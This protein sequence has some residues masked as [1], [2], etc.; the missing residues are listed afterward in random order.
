MSTP[1]V[2]TVNKCICIVC[3]ILAW[4]LTDVHPAYSGAW[5]RSKKSYYLKFSLNDYIALSSFDRNGRRV[6]IASDGTVAGYFNEFSLFTYLEYGMTDRLTLVGSLPLKRV[7]NN[8]DSNRGLPANASAGI[9]DINIGLKYGLFTRPIVV[10]LM[11]GIK[12]PAY[13][14]SRNAAPSLGSAQVDGDFSLLIGRSLWPLPAYVTGDMGY[15]LR[16]GHFA[17]QLT[18]NFEV[19]V[20]L[21]SY[22]LLRGTLG[23]V[24][25]L[26]DIASMQ[27][28]TNNPNVGDQDYVNA[29][30][31][32]I[33]KVA[34][35]LDMS[36]DYTR[37]I[38]G[39]NAAVGN[40]I[41]VGVALK[42]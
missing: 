18:Y 22:V 38:S 3:L 12:L 7:S 21:G 33:F 19:G 13:A 28:M 9:G 42:R 17:N 5:A 6:E 27:S 15:R 39:R 29:G 25:S 20:G 4:T 26:V 32:L 10:S 23:G 14:E 36:L 11:S 16:G 2:Y 1:K 40:S 30:S 31:G 8:N 41:S 34:P 37:T 24:Y 35:H